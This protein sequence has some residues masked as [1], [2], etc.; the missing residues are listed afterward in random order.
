[1]VG[2]I[3][4]ENYITE[5]GSIESKKKGP[6]TEPWGTPYGSEK[7]SEKQLPSLTFCLQFET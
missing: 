3:E 4:I 7:V 5:R 2:D 6:R 1:M